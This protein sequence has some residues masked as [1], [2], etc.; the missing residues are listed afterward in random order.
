MSIARFDHIAYGVE[1]PTATFTTL[2]SR[3]GLEWVQWDTNVGFAAL[4]AEFP[5]GFKIEVIHP[6]EAE[7]NPFMRRFLDRHGNAPHHLTF[8]LQGIESY[9]ERLGSIGVEPVAVRLDTPAW[10]EAFVHSRGGIGVL[11]QLAE[12]DNDLNTE[13]PPEWP[14]AA[15]ETAR[16]VRL[17]HDVEHLG[18]ACEILAAIDGTP[19]DPS[20]DDLGDFID[21]V[22]PGERTL[23]LRP[24]S[25]QP[26]GR[27]RCLVVDRLAGVDTGRPAD[28]FADPE[29][30]ATICV[31][32]ADA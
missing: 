24:S 4:Q 20:S 14:D 29:L 23:R 16:F 6:F 19:Q 9:L 30:G 25:E 12:S 15:P 22:W 7:R 2:R 18:R 11:L 17:E 1:H 10:R 3:L 8:R 5:S 26:D 32:A 31:E 13:A 21:V 28:P 27:H